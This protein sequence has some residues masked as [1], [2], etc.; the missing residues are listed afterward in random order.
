MAVL[1]FRAEPSKRSPDIAKKIETGGHSV[2]HS[3]SL[4]I[5]L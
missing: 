4:R 1:F 5:N 2:R 3:A